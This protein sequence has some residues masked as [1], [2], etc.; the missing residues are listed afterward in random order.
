MPPLFCVRML[1]LDG[2]CAEC[3]AFYYK[4]VAKYKT[5]IAREVQFCCGALYGVL[6]VVCKCLRMLLLC[7][8]KKLARR[9][10]YT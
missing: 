6:A 3:A 9:V 7:N 2:Y 8:F 10:L 5:G 1:V 4:I